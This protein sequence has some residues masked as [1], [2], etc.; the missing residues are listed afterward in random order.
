MATGGDGILRRLFP[1]R[2]WSVVQRFRS[3]EGRSMTMKSNNG[4]DDFIAYAANTSMA[5]GALV[6]STTAEQVVEVAR[7]HGF[8]FSADQLRQSLLV[9]PLQTLFDAGLDMGMMPF[10]ASRADSPEHSEASLEALDSDVS[11]C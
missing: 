7:W 8:N 6:A 11:T 2:A 4:P 1:L 9:L 3:D 5:R 10:L